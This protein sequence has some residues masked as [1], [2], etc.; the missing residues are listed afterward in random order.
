MPLPEIAEYIRST[1][2]VAAGVNIDRSIVAPGPQWALESCRQWVVHFGAGRREALGAGRT[3]AQQGSG[4]PGPLASGKVYDLTATFV[5][6]GFPVWDQ[7]E[8]ADANEVNAWSA[9]FLADVE[10]LGQ[11]LAELV[12]PASLVGVPGG[13]L[14]VGASDPVGPQG[15]VARVAWPLSVQVAI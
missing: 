12:F 15:G 1:I 7:E 13:K 9:R 14:S 6:C 2:P 11:A 5:S 10:A 4:F 3:P 8:P